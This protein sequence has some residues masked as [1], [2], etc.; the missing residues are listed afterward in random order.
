MKN[1]ASVNQH[2]RPYLIILQQHNN[3]TRQETKQQIEVKCSY[4]IWVIR[5]KLGIEEYSINLSTE[6]TW[7]T[8]NTGSVSQQRNLI[9]KNTLVDNIG[10]HYFVFLLLPHGSFIFT[11]KCAVFL[12]LSNSRFL[13]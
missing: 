13:T 1:I 9:F 6:I 5:K 10:D 4:F 2:W 3:Q 11:P 7:Y 12:F 8:K